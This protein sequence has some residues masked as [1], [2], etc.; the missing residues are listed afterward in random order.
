MAENKSKMHLALFAIGTGH[1]VSGWRMPDAEAGALD[2][3]FFR[4]ISD[5]AERGKFDLFFLA[6]ALSAATSQH[7]S[8]IVRL[9]P[10]TLLA[11]LATVTSRIGLA[12]TAISTYTEPYNLARYFASL[13][14]L[15]GGRA[16]WNVVTGAFPEAADNFGKD[17]HPDHSTRYAMADEFV[18]VVRGLWDSWEDGA[19]VVDKQTGRYLDTS[20]LHVLDHDG[21]YY[22]VKGPLNTARPPQGHPVIIQA[23][24]SDTGRDFAAR[25][26][27][28]V[29][30]VQ[31]DLETAKAF[32]T[33]MRTRAES[34]GRDPNSIKVMPGVSPIVA[35]TEEEAR[36]IIEKLG[37]FADP[38]TALRILSERIGHDLSAYSLDDPVPAFP[39][40]TKMQ[41]HSVNL[42]RMA[43]EYNMTLRQ[44]RDYASAAQG[45]RLIWGT[46]ERIADELQA[47]FDAGA[48]DGF[49]IMPAYFPS[50]LDAFVDRVIPILQKRGIFRTEYE[51]TTLRGHLGLSRPPHA[52]AAPFDAHLETARS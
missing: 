40:S 39:P 26:A 7:P 48:A 51:S 14:H 44:L 16:A 2:F 8:Y 30:A 1:H 45:H 31:Q 6:D 52:A 21:P 29:F 35:D 23:G 27:E 25:I 32:R 9:E 41:G 22:R 38:V 18:S 10:I 50:A 12:A 28:V 20:K 5:T 3:Q 47:W 19:L 13:D 34:A 11:A 33:D 24:A 46:P 36:A 15:S 49:T 4:Q 37:Q 42:A 43:K 17:P